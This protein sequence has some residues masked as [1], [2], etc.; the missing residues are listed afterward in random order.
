MMYYVQ[1]TAVWV[2]K[3]SVKK[4]KKQPPIEAHSELPKYLFAGFCSLLV[5]I[6]DGQG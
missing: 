4:N 6:N 3:S 5:F 1:I 2:V